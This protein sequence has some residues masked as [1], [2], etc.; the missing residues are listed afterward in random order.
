MDINNHNSSFITSFNLANEIE[1]ILDPIINPPSEED[2][3][4]VILPPPPPTADT[5]APTSTVEILPNSVPEDF[6]VTW[7]GF[8]SG[9]SGIA[10]YDV[11]VS[12]DGGDFQLW[13]DDTTSLS[14][15]Y[16]G[17]SDRS[18]EFFSV[19]TDNAGNS[20]STIQA[21]AETRT[22]GETQQPAIYRLFNTSTGVHLY[23]ANIA[24]RGSVI[25]N[26]SNYQYEGV[27]YFA[28]NP[29]EGVPVYRLYNPIVDGH[30]YT[31]SEAERDAILANNSDYVLEGE[32]FTAFADEITAPEGATPVYRFFIP[33]SGAYFYTISEVERDSIIANLPNYS[34][35]GIAFYSFPL[36]A[37]FTPL[38]PAPEPDNT[39]FLGANIF[40]QLYGPDATTPITGGLFAT[41]G[42][43]VEFADLPSDDL[44]GGLVPIDMN[45]DIAATSVIFE[46]EQ[47]GSGTSASGDLNA[48]I[49][50]D[51]DNSLP[52]IQNI[53]IDTAAT[54]LDIDSNDIFFTE[55]S[56]VVN[57]AGVDYTQGD[58]IKLDFA[59]GAED[60]LP[61]EEPTETSNS[62][63]LGAELQY[64]TYSP[65]FDTPI[66]DPLTATVGDGIEF[67]LGIGGNG[68]TGGF[69][70][71]RENSIVYEVDF[72]EDS[73]FTEAEFNGFVILD[74][75]NSLPAIE[76]ITI[77]PS[78]TTLDI[79]EFDLV[80]TEDG[81][82]VNLEGIPFSDGDTLQLNVDFV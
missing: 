58:T 61:T 18:Y 29:G 24:E 23:T 27:S 75:S 71:I 46:V 51:S 13:Q 45:I 4:E 68:I 77:D 64:Q 53:I 37:D 8:D 9:G 50:V 34:Y 52:P 81:L 79:S 40:L 48:Y 12:I 62:N 49:F 33:D 80:F 38:P 54:T 56:F 67:D 69:V 47:A 26:L 76:N 28:A 59:F 17:Q 44:D 42:D 2:S 78:G 35:E 16:N 39:N 55:D 65:N 60:S 11:F 7:Y 25:Q 5:E 72:T 15:V 36:D 66:G 22:D 14:G 1:N 19:A 70:D 3:E 82:A 20:E 6:T 63:F 21:Q 74:V 31:V 43:G 10:S 73:F 57:V 41:V 30:F 32:A